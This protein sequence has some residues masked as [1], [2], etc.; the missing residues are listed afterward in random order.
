MP[1]HWNASSLRSN[2]KSSSCTTSNSASFWYCT[3]SAGRRLLLAHHSAGCR[4]TGIHPLTR[5]TLSLHH[6]PHPPMWKGGACALEMIQKDYRCPL[7]PTR[8]LG[9]EVKRDMNRQ[10]SRPNH[11]SI[12]SLFL[13]CA[14]ECLTDS[15]SLDSSVVRPAS[16]SRRLQGRN[17]FFEPLVR[18]HPVSFVELSRGVL[19]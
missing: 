13:L 8:R 1:G 11:A 16:A 6:H 17:G 2:Q 3:W 10:L 9:S 19:C 15:Q 14:A 7:S 12:L 4:P 18:H 5:R